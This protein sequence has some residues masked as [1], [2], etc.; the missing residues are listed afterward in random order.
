MQ[1][2]FLKALKSYST[3]QA[4]TLSQMDTYRKDLLRAARDKIDE[5]LFNKVLLRL[6]PLPRSC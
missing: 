6:S 2:T 1:K 3:Q 5:V 4:I